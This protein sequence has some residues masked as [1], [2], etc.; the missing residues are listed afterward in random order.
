MKFALAFAMCLL[1]AASCSALLPKKPADLASML[2]HQQFAMRRMISTF[3]ARA[4]DSSLVNDCFNHYLDDQRDVI[5]NYNVKYNGC[6]NTAQ[7]S[8]DILTAQSASERQSLLDRT[9]AMCSSLTSCDEQ[10]DGLKF[11]ECYRDSS[12]NSY[13]TMFTLNSDSNLDFNRISA[14]YSVI[15]TDLTD[16]VDTARNDYARDMD[17]CDESLTVC[18][19]GGVVTDAPVTDAPTTAA[20]VTDGPTTAAPVTDAPTTA[21]PV[22]DAPTTAAPVTDAPTT[23]APN[24]VQSNLERE[25]TGNIVIFL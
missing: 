2:S 9:N 24:E 4:D 10:V 21:A 17:S 14:S 8:R 5:I 3:D 25:N 7:V 15:E 11:F 12:A 23:A 18:L 16:C 20:P 13:K 22:T 1:L 19:A 6:I